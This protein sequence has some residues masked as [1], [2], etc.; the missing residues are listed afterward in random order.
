MWDESSA[1]HSCM[2]RLYNKK[3]VNPLQ[4]NGEPTASFRRCHYVGNPT[5]P[6]RPGRSAYV[7]L[8]HQEQH[9]MPAM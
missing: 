4:E 3:M 9:V 2:A 1:L 6:G 8:D 7:G 5:L